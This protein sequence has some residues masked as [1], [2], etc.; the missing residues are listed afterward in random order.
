MKSI[1]RPDGS[2]ALIDD[3]TAS[4]ME[5]SAPQPTLGSLASTLANT[6][7]VQVLRGGSANGAAFGTEVLATATD[8]GVIQELRDALR[9]H[10]GGCGHCMCHGDPSLVLYGNGGD[11][12]AVLGLHHG[13]AIRWCEWKDD[14]ELIDGER[15]LKWLADSG[16]AYPKEDFQRRR[17]AALESKAHAARWRAATPPSLAAHPIFDLELAVNPAPLVPA[18]ESSLPDPRVR[19]LALLAWL[20]HGVGPW[21][22]CPAYEMLPEK[23]LL[24]MPMDQLL[25]A[26]HAE[27]LTEAHVEGAARLFA[28][29]DFGKKR[30]RDLARLTERDKQRLLEHAMRSPD[31]DKQARA[32]KAFKPSR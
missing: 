15:L 6:R 19:A 21:S 26:L 31:T 23:L 25:E 29:W 30:K 3:A 18:L 12:I 22:G 28:G 14:A 1:T 27:N 7:R 32:R 13:V 4:Y 5:S 17:L 10:D 9:I 16:V 24:A 8:S 2:K 20:G 11:V